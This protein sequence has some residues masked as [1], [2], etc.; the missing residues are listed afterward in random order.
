MTCRQQ[1]KDRVTIFFPISP[2]IDDFT[3]LFSL[4]TNG[5]KYIFELSIFGPYVAQYKLD[6]LM[7]ACFTFS[8]LG[9]F[10]QD[11]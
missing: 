1:T 6:N 3:L 10:Y 7:E 4:G 5:L 8:K 2:S 11:K 9:R